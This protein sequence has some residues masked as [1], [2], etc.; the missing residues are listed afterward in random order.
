V[1]QENEYYAFGLNVNR[2]NVSP[3]N[4]YL[5]NGKELQ[6]DYGW[7]RYD[8]GARFYDPVIARWNAVDPMAETMRRWSPYSYAFDNP[9][10]FID[11]DGMIPDDPKEKKKETTYTAVITLGAQFI[12]DVKTALG[13]IGV[14]LNAVSFDVIGVRDSKF[15][16]MEGKKQSVGI[17]G[18]VAKA[19]SERTFSE[20]SNGEDKVERTTTVTTGAGFG[21]RLYPKRQSKY[22]MLIMRQVKRRRK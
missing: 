2:T 10:R 19:R 11:P 14:E 16:F 6:E 20:K 7:N 15:V 1:E 12:G 5:Y 3:E 4:K 22:Q 21:P 18:L 17:E 8:Y 9:I 13:G